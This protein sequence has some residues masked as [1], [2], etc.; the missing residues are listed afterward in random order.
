M[1]GLRIEGSS[2]GLDLLRVDPQPP[3]VEPLPHGKV[4]EIA[5]SHGHFSPLYP[6]SAWPQSAHRARLGTACSPLQ[7]AEA[8]RGYTI[9]RLLHIRGIAIC[10][11]SKNTASWSK[12][13]L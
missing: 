11:H 1:E 7:G 12:A 2:E 13:S 10:L 9:L 6:N 5:L 8:P 4:F 3:G